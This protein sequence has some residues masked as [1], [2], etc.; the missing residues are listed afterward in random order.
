[1]QAVRIDALIEETFPAAYRLDMTLELRDLNAPR[2]VQLL[3]SNVSGESDHASV[4]E[5]DFEVGGR[6]W[7]ATYRSTPHFWVGQ[8][9]LASWIIL[10]P[11]C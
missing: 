11:A 4:F 5:R 8:P 6:R 3:Y 1:M 10:R 9:L 7:R 2:P